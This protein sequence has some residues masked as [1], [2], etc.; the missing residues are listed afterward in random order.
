[1]PRVWI[2]V[3]TPKQARL[4][5]AL[6]RRLVGFE[7]LFTAR[8]YD[9]TVATLRRLGI[10]PIVAGGYGYSLREKVVEEARRIEALASVVEGCSMLLAYPNPSAARLAYGL[11]IPYIAFTDSPHSVHPSRLSLPLATAVVAPSCIP[12]REIT[13]F[14][15]PGTHVEMYR[16][17]DEVEWLKLFKPSRASLKELG[18]EERSYVVVRPPEVRASYYGS[19]GSRV[20]SEVAK[21]VEWCLG[22]GLSVVY[23]PRYA[24]DELQERFSGSR[25]FTIVDRSRG[26]D[27]ADLTYH[28]LAVV[29]GG[30][31]MAREA[32]LL[33]TLGICLYPSRLYVDDFVEALGLPHARASSALQ[34]IELIKGFSRDPDRYRTIAREVTATLEAPSDALL[35]VLEELGIGYGE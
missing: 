31:S 16:G 11:A 26:V 33:G 17:V 4:F 15:L 21:I 27:G 28:A 34:A 14:T 20:L 19:R 22:E 30:G 3:L 23:M 35:R 13:R 25:G 18:L 10:D 8:D 32:A 7:I 9:Y 12:M 24:R 6:S 1:M 29:T 5:A 2:D